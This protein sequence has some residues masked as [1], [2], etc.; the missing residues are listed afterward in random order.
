MDRRAQYWSRLLAALNAWATAAKE[1]APGQVEVSFRDE[2]GLDRRA[3]LVM[4]PEGLVDMISASW[5]G[6]DDAFARVRRGLVE[7]PSAQEYLVYSNHRLLPSAGPYP[8]Q[9]TAEPEIGSPEDIKKRIRGTWM[10]ALL[11]G[12]LWGFYIPL[13]DEAYFWISSALGLTS[14]VAWGLYRPWIVPSKSA[15]NKVSGWT[16]VGI[17]GTS[18]TLS[19]L[20]P[21]EILAIVSG[22]FLSGACGHAAVSALRYRRKS[23]GGRPD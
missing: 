13:A 20:V 8:P 23:L 18:S 17:A 15:R 14:G 5:N 21:T 2:Q 12:L 1:V 10:L 9:T 19:R 16:I 6:F 4:T 3:V 22:A 11:M 7:M